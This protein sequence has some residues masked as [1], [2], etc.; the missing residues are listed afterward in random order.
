VNVR[1]AFPFGCGDARGK[2]GRDALK[3]LRWVLWFVGCFVPVL[4]L[5]GHAQHVPDRL[6]DIRSRGELHCGIWP[7]VTGFAVKSGNSYQGFDIDFCRAMAASVFADAAK[8]KFVPV[9]SVAA[10]RERSDVDL[11]IRRLTWTL[12]REGEAHAS[13][14][15][16]IFFDGQGFLVEKS[17][18]ITNAAQL[19]NGPICVIDSERHPQNLWNYLHDH[20]R[21]NQLVLVSDNE[22]AEKALD[23]KRCTAYSADVSWLAAARAGFSGGLSRYAILADTI[24]K[25][26]LAPM[27]RVEDAE[28][29]RLVRW[30]IFAMIEAEEAG[31]TSRNID[32][33][34]RS[35]RAQK[36]LAVRPDV[37]VAAA[38][39]TWV[40]HIISSVGNYGEVYERNL[41]ANSTLRLERGVNR[42]WTEGGLLY[43][44]PLE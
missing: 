38:A 10:L 35:I 9:E 24:S 43:A 15:P 36:L 19:G 5:W 30:T 2:G 6:T 23:A 28:F 41:G 12:P 4:P 42:V 7:E 44:L 14:G 33:S 3:A 37:D 13:F 1:R 31:V 26:P 27:F 20:G 16:I 8:I 17:S 25:E 11:V 29:A 39:G 40:R 34:P 32:A 22:Q 21:D 18:G